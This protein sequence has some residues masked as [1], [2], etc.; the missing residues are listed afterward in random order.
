METVQKTVC[1]VECYIPL[2]VSL[3]VWKILRFFIC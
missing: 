2:S 3:T 1:D